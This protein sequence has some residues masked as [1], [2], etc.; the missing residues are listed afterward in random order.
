[1][2]NSRNLRIPNTQLLAVVRAAIY[3]GQQVQEIPGLGRNQCFSWRRGQHG[4]SPDQTG[5]SCIRAPYN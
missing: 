4:L 3:S 2:K 5:E 1:M